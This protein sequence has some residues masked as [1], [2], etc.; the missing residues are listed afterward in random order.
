MSDIEKIDPNHPPAP[1]R[2]STRRGPFTTHNGPWYHWADETG[3]RQGVRLQDRHCNSR[4]HAH[5]GFLSSLADGLLATAVFR[6][7]N[8]GSVT[9]QLTTEFLLPAKVG[10]WVQG[11]AWLNRATKSLAFVEA[12]AWVGEGQEVAKS[13]MVFTSHAVF[14]LKE[15]QPRG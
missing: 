9:V 8:R 12:C 5:G 10:Q 6:N 4:G 13:D 14:K 15:A 3:F 1:F 2:R 7:L 11:T